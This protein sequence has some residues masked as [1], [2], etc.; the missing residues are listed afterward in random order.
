V[1]TYVNMF[2]CV[3]TNIYQSVSFYGVR[4][5]SD[6]HSTLLK[7]YLFDWVAIHHLLQGIVLRL[8]PVYLK[9]KLFSAHSDMAENSFLKWFDLNLWI[10]FHSLLGWIRG[11]LLW[12]DWIRNYEFIWFLWRKVIDCSRM[13]ISWGCWCLVWLSSQTS[14]TDKLSVSGLTPVNNS[15]CKA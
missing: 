14:R 12:N 1:Y 2:I 7:F 10:F 13:L 4:T 6:A 15:V 11:K 8:K 5:L 3:Y 9:K